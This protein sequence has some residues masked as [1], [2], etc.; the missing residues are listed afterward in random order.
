[1]R[2]RG[3]IMKK[4]LPV[5]ICAAFLVIFAACSKQNKNTEVTETETV[6]STTIIY[7]YPDSQ[8]TVT[9]GAMNQS[10]QT[11][12]QF[13]ATTSQGGSQ[14]VSSTEYNGVLTYYSENPNNKYIRMAADKFG[15]DPNNFIALIKVNAQY[16][17]A[18][19]L[20]FDGSRDSSGRLITTADHL[21]YFY[22][23]A[24]SGSIK[25]SNKDGSDVTG[26]S[27]NKTINKVAGMT[28]YKLAE[29]EMIP[30]LDNL[31][32]TMVYEEHF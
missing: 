25:R 26:F 16:P 13:V 9:S 1:M 8:E 12:A 22:D 3:V 7:T 18:S 5:I 4:Y 20:Q 21:V 32:R 15:Q 14:N 31:K 6:T 24:D 10:D 30:R 2:L 19:V 27:D 17:G 23:V 28:A 29:D 11:N